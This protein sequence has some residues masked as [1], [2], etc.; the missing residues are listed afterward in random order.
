MNIE[1]N[2]LVELSR[3]FIPVIAFAG[4]YIAWQQFT[5]HRDKLRFDLFD[6]RFK[7]YD[8]IIN[9]MYE[10]LYGAEEI[11]SEQYRRFKTACN[12]AQFLLPK[13]VYGTV[14]V[15]KEIF[16]ELHTVKLRIKRYSKKD[17]GESKLTEL[18]EKA[19]ELEEKLEKTHPIITEKF[20][21]V[22]RFEK[23]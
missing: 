17:D 15:A 12:E 19:V 13:N 5:A 6:R 4:I 1:L 23:F 20:G 10:Y 22:L 18:K 3:L 21:E 8:D 9:S 11:D 14:N 7:V 16:S 2:T